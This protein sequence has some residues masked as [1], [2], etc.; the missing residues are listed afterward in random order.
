MICRRLIL[1][2]AR[3]T[4]LHMKPRPSRVGVG[5]NNPLYAYSSP[6]FQERPRKLKV[7]RGACFSVALMDAHIL[8]S[9][10][11]DQHCSQHDEI[12]VGT[13][14]TAVLKFP[15]SP[16]LQA[17]GWISV[18][19]TSRVLA[20]DKKAQNMSSR[21]DNRQFPEHRSDI[22]IEKLSFPVNEDCSR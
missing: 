6:A 10:W 2:Q 22:G 20:V 21:D 4:V 9:L 15:C 14:K 16:E 1:V 11:R 7:K 12:I 3:L 17:E 13:R 19:T 8:L 18:L 5:I